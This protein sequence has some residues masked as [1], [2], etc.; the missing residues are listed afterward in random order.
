M[1]LRKII[2][3]GFNLNRMRCYNG[4]FNVSGCWA[5]T[6]C[7]NHKNNNRFVMKM[8]NNSKFINYNIE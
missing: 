6:L 2:N 1:G 8:I 3:S 7:Y 4:N 5:I